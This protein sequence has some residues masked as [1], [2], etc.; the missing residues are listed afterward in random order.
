M[1]PAK[2]ELEAAINATEIH[3]RGSIDMDTLPPCNP[4]EIQANLVAQL[5]ASAAET[6]EYGCDGALYRMRTGAVLQGL[7][8]KIDGSSAA[9]YCL[10]NKIQL[11]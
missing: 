5:T 4:A 2:V 1:S 7:I 10:I 9:R 8:K 3:A 11:S 6:E